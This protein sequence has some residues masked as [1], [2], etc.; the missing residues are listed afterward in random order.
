[1][2]RVPIRAVVFDLFDTLVDLRFEDLP[3]QEHRGKRLPASVRQLH[4]EI[5]RAHAVELDALVE[6]MIEGAKAFDASHFANDREVKTEERFE[7]TLARL[8]IASPELVA[9]M[10]EIHMGVLAS[11]VRP[12]PHHGDLLASLRPRLRVGLCSNFSHSRTAERVLES[13]G[14]AGAFDAV[15]VSDAFGLRKP[16]REIFDEVLKRL[17]VAAE[18]TLHVGDS[19][20][21]D[22]G[23]ARGAGLSAAW[24]TR[25]VR[26]PEAALRTHEG[27]KPDHAIADLAELPALLASL[28]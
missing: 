24:I 21:A 12:L 18:E 25:R 27:P 26:D 1:L 10:T 20:R 19:L 8:G 5:A 23:G 14:L 6:A 16:R 17:G 13:A 22:V 9:R 28:A 15:V 4:D 7:D 3:V 2:P 11:A